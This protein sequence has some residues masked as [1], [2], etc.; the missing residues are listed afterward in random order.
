VVKLKIGS[1]FKAC[2]TSSFFHVE[3][4]KEKLFA[5]LSA[6]MWHSWERLP[7]TT[8][9]TLAFKLEARLASQS[10]N[11]VA[12]QLAFHNKLMWSLVLSG[13]SPSVWDWADLDNLMG[14]ASMTA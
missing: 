2:F 7:S 6:L 3:S 4:Y 8:F 5:Q 14:K 12:R 10:R 1:N 13:G 9:L 11:Q